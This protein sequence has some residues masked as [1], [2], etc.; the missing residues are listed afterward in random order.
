MGQAEF[1]ICSFQFEILAERAEL[2]TFNVQ[3]ATCTSLGAQ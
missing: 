3:S 2:A 1:S